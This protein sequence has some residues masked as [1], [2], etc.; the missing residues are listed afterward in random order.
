MWGFTVEHNFYFIA[1]Q[2]KDSVTRTYL[3][4]PHLSEKA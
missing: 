3:K 1:N 4:I 2:V